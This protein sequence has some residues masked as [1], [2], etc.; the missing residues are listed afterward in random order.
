MLMMVIYCIRLAFSAYTLLLLCRI[1]G[2]W[3][4]QLRS[5]RFMYFV[6]KYTDPYLMIFR[7]VIPPIGGVLDLSPILAFFSL[8]LIERMLL[9]FIR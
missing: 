4:P 7:R 5:H 1:I 2:S 3:L 6:G 8:R 9:F